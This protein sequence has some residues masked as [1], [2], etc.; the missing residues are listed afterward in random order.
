MKCPVVLVGLQVVCQVVFLETLAIILTN[1][2][3]KLNVTR[4][5][6]LSAEGSFRTEACFHRTEFYEIW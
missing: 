4:F 2:L 5:L 6:K 1:G 3:L